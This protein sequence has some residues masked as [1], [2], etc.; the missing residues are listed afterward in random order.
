MNAND[1]IVVLCYY[2]DSR[3]NFIRSTLVVRRHN[4]HGLTNLMVNRY[5]GVSF[6]NSCTPHPHKT[7]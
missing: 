2:V 6:Y 7:L 5:G 4:N 3:F 1:T